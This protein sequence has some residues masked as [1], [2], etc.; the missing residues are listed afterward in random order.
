MGECMIFNTKFGFVNVIKKPIINTKINFL[1]TKKINTI[2]EGAQKVVGVYEGVA[3]IIKQ[4]YPMIGNIKTTMRVARAFSKINN[5]KTLEDAF[6][7]LPDFDSNDN[8][9]Y[10]AKVENPFFPWYNTIR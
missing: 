4:Y 5:S 9:L 10:A 1:N 8:E 7:K 2:I 3:P 6:D